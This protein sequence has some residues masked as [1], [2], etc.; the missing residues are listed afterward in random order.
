MGFYP[1][2]AH[3]LESSRLQSHGQNTWESAFGLRKK[4]GNYL[5]MPAFVQRGQQYPLPAPNQQN[6]VYLIQQKY[7]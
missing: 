4:V 3:Y 7:F 1:R 2:Q 6:R 5:L